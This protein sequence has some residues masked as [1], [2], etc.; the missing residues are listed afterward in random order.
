MRVVLAA[1]LLEPDGALLAAVGLDRRPWTGE[2]MIDRRDLVVNNISI[3]LVGV[4]SLPDDGLIILMERNA[5][6]AVESARAFHI[7]GLDFERVEAAGSSRV[8][9]LADGIARIARLDVRRPSASVGIDSA[10]QGVRE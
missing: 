10:R 9:P 1:I 4:D 3:G 8:E 2:R 6:G 7:A 5:R